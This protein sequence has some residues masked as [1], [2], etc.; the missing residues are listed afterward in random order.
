MIESKSLDYPLWQAAGRASAGRL[1]LAEPFA[2]VLP[3]PL[4]QRHLA[5]SP[6]HFRA[7]WH[8]LGFPPWPGF[9]QVFCVPCGQG[10][11]KKLALEGEGTL[12]SMTQDD[13]CM[14]AVPRGGTAGREAPRTGEERGTHQSCRKCA[15]RGSWLTWANPDHL[16]RAGPWPGHQDVTSKAGTGISTC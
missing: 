13:P 5:F 2:H 14:S 7:Q 12:L 16:E 4:N 3:E 9:G 6:S 1:G 10:R 8:K 15:G 11:P